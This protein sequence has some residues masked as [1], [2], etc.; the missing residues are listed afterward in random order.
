MEFAYPNASRRYI[1]ERDRDMGRG[2]T[3][4]ALR[5]V[6]F[7]YASH[8]GDKHIFGRA[9]FGDRRASIWEVLDLRIRKHIYQPARARQPRSASGGLSFY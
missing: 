1:L 2:R 5:V 4:M 9:S 8:E 3:D 7:I 6:C